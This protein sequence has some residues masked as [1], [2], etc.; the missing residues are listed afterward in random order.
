MAWIGREKDAF[1]VDASATSKRLVVVA[2][3]FRGRV[4]LGHHKDLRGHLLLEDPDIGT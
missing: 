2:A 3:W 1:S 4:T